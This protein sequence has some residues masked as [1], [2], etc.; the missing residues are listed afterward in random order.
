MLTF[1]DVDVLG[2]G[3]GV[4]PVRF[5]LQMKGHTG[6]EVGVMIVDAKWHDGVRFVAVRARDTAGAMRAFLFVSNEAR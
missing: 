4:A 6:V 2:Y 3:T 1:L 5:A